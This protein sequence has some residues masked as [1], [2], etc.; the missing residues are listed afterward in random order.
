MQ[1]LMLHEMITCTRRVRGRP[2]QNEGVTLVMRVSWK[3]GAVKQDPNLSI[4]LELDVHHHC[5]FTITI[6]VKLTM[7]SFLAIYRA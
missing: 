1:I 2:L 4:G 6:I 5:L 3:V 7:D